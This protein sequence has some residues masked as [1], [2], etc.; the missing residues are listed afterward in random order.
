[1]YLCVCVYIRTDFF[2]KYV[3]ILFSPSFETSLPLPPASSFFIASHCADMQICMKNK[4]HF[5]KYGPAG[6]FYLLSQQC[7]KHSAREYEYTVCPF[8]SVKQ[9]SGPV[10]NTVLGRQG[11]WTRQKSGDY[12]LSMGYGDA[13]LCPDGQARQ[14]EV[15]YSIHPTILVFIPHEKTFG[16]RAS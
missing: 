10:I 15:R 13:S 4:N 5:Q 9:S 16:F 7:F 12:V 2:A 8:E 3:F 11:H 1:M 14:T 6:I